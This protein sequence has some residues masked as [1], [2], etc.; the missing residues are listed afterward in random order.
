M[1][2]LIKRK[3]AAAILGISVT[4]L[5]AARMEGLITY[6]QYVDN[7]CVYFTDTALKE[8]MARCTYRARPKEQSQ[9][10]RRPRTGR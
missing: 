3:E 7:G 5:D 10:Y 9:T 4:T 1:D 8:Y 2:R 6:I